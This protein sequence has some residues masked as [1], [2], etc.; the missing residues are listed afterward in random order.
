MEMKL[1]GSVQMYHQEDILYPRTSHNKPVPGAGLNFSDL[2]IRLPELFIILYI[3][4]GLSLLVGTWL[5][6]KGILPSPIVLLN[7]G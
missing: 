3:V 5:V 7:R 4:L 2:E 6:A 1:P